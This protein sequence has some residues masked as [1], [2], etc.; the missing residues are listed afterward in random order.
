MPKRCSGQENERRSESPSFRARLVAVVDVVA[1]A[2]AFGC[3]YVAVL[4]KHVTTSVVLL[5]TGHTP[6]AGGHVCSH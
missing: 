1:V 5:R 3:G 2:V 6:Q 4:D